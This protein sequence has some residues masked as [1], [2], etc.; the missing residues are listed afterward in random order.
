MCTVVATSEDM[1]LAGTYNFTLNP[2][3]RVCEAMSQTAGDVVFLKEIVEDL[4]KETE[5]HYSKMVVAMQSCDV[6]ACKF[7]SH[8]IKGAAANLFAKQ[9]QHS[10]TAI[11]HLCKLALGG[12]SV[13]LSGLM[14]N[15]L[16]CNFGLWLR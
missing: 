12:V 8:S 4:R 6:K 7:S 15:C 16:H 11:E 3:A 5:E 14:S 13:A 10:S 1:T 2:G 9:L